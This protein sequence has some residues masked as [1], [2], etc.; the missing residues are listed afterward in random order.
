MGNLFIVYEAAIALVACCGFASEATAGVFAV[1]HFHF[2]NI[3][4]PARKIKTVYIE[5]C[6]YVR[7]SHDDET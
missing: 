3:R 4:C 1:S 7:S 2:E 6:W 5:D